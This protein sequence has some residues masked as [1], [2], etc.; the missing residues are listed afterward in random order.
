M[1]RYCCRIPP[2]PNPFPHASGGK[3][4]QIAVFPFPHKGGRTK[5]GGQTSSPTAS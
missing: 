4:T 2:S 1:K 5:D 3:G